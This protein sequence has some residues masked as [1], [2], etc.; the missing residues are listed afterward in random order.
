MRKASASAG[1][2]V[3]PVGE[4]VVERPVDAERRGRGSGDG[5]ADRKVL[6]DRSL[7]AFGDDDVGLELAEGGEA[8]RV[9][10]RLQRLAEDVE[11]VGVAR[12]LEGAVALR[13]GGLQRGGH[14]PVGVRVAHAALLGAHQDEGEALLLEHRRLVVELDGELE[15][16]EV[17]DL[18]PLD[19]RRAVE[20]RRV[21][22][23]PHDHPAAVR[24]RREGRSAGTSWP[25]LRRSTPSP[26]S[27]IA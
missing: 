14:A 15:L 5:S 13:I 16:A 3:R 8:G 18:G 27:R 19:D 17:A 2:V 10:D 1:V 26:G 20:A 6:V 24:R 12:V 23:C 11:A 7:E 25:Y 9:L 21:H 22:R 4:V